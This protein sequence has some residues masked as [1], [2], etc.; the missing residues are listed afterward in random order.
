MV[1]Q[2]ASDMNA[3]VA[4]Y[5]RAAELEPDWPELHRSLGNALLLAGNAAEAIACFRK[6]NSL[7]AS[8]P[9]IHVEL[10]RALMVSG[11]RK[12]ALATC[13]AY[14][15]SHPYQGALVAAR[16]QLI[17]NEMGSE[18][19]SRRLF[20]LETFVQTKEIEAA[21]RLRRHRCF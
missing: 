6:S 5:K 11:D 18:A 10:A 17:L 15:A 7:A 3:A 13:D 12:G 21:R 19:Q 20:G 14:M 1:H 2:A 9:D 16:P 4:G 8:E